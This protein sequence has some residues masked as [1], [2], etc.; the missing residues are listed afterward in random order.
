M[1]QSHFMLQP[2]SR[3]TLLGFLMPDDR[4]NWYTTSGD[5]GS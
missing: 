5:A 2:R 4:C 1:N 3:L